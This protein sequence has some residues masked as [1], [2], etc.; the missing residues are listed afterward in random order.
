MIEKLLASAIAAGQAAADIYVVDDSSTD[1]TGAK[2][3]KII[4]KDNVVRVSRGGKGR[5]IEAGVAK[6]DLTNKYQWIH[7]ADAD[8]IFGAGY[9]DHFKSRLNRGK[10]SAAIGYV[11]SLRGDW[12]SRYRTYEYTWGQTVN[13]RLQAFF[14]VIPVVPGPT[15][16]IHAKIFNKLSFDNDTMTEDFDAT[17]QIYRKGLGKIAFFPKAVIYTQDPMS[18][19]DFIKQITRWYRGYFQSIVN[20]RVSFEPTKIDYYLF[21]LCAQALLYS[22]LQFVVV[23]LAAILS[24]NP[25]VIALLFLTDLVIF[26]AMATCTAIISR[27]YDIMAAFPLFYIARMTAIVVF[28]RSFV[29]VVLFRKF[30]NS[31]SIWETQGRRYRI[32]IGREK[33]NA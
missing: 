6:F 13:R 23:P 26:I 29:E 12:I 31:G 28:L 8:G 16:C 5:A 30:R 21:Y 15:A 25:A 17:L 20:H 19:R 3:R 9:F 18:Y 11:Q 24:G 7:I 1:R 10:H 2:A 22:M 14:G 33:V 27:R 4:G 32:H